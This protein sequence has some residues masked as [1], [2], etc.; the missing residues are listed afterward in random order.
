AKFPYETKDQR[1]RVLIYETSGLN[2][3]KIAGAPVFF[4]LY[5]GYSLLLRLFK[6][7]VKIKTIS[8]TRILRYT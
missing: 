2:I 1:G 6:I 4:G 7:K 3:Q 5:S 8:I